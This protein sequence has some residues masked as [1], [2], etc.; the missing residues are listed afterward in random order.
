M[1]GGLATATLLLVHETAQRPSLPRS[2]QLSSNVKVQELGDGG[3]AAL[4]AQRLLVGMGTWTKELGL[5]TQGKFKRLFELAPDLLSEFKP[6][7]GWVFETYL[8]D[9]SHWTYTDTDIV[10]G[11]SSIFPG[12]NLITVE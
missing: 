11:R 2:C 4:H 7:W 8:Y 1:V 9:F 5:E 3:I 10:F 12:L 6:S